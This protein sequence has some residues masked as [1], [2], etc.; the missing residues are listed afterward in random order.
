MYDLLT[1]VLIIALL[2]LSYLVWKRD[3]APQHPAKTITRLP[4][5][6]AQTAG[7]TI[8]LRGF[9]CGRTRLGAAPADGEFF[10]AA[11]RTSDVFE[12]EQEGFELGTIEGNLDYLYLQLALFHGRFRANGTDL[13]L[14]TATTPSEIRALFGEPYWTDD[15]DDETILFY[16]YEAGAIELQFEFPGKQRLDVI[17]LMRNG[18]LS[19]QEQRAAYRLTK[20]WPPA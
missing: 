16:E 2:G 1:A 15:D 10:T 7:L 9:T 18:V 6:A 4:R 11:L 8:D 12:L 13:A 14:T 20:P 3:R 19:K 5:H 17:T